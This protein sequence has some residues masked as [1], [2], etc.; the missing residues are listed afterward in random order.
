MSSFSSS[1][2]NR[3]GRLTSNALEL[4]FPGTCLLCGKA[5]LF[6]SQPFYPVCDRCVGALECI[7]DPRCRICGRFLISERNICTRCRER[8]YH[9]SEHRSLYEYR[10]A[11]RELVYQLKFN[12]RRRVS[13]IL[14]DHLASTLNDCYPGLTLVPVPARRGRIRERGWDHMQLISRHISR[15]YGIKVYRCLSRG[16]DVPQKILNFE[17]RVHNIA[18]SGITFKDR[19]GPLVAAS[20][21]VLIDDVFTTGATVDECARI[22]LKGGVKKVHVLT[23]AQD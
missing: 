3:S 21:V 19:D 23:F 1:R 4:L 10:G 15:R 22:L 11:V 20:E 16:G 17:Q 6:Q 7:R 13:L 18:A 12:G 9:F 8:S 14:A 5:L 2:L